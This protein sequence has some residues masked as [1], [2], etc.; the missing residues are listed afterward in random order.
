VSAAAPALDR[1]LVALLAVAC[2]ATVANLYYAQPLLSAIA[3]AFGVSEGTAGL[4]VTVSQV[5]YAT[6]LV[7]VVPLGDLLDRRRLVARLLS[8]C[9]CG[10]ILAGSA[11]ALPVLA[12]ALGAVALT[13]VVVQIL[14]PF[15]STLA[16]ESERGQVVGTIMSGV[17]TGI[18]LARTVSG[19]IAEAAGWRAPFF[20]AAG[21]MAVLGVALWRALPR[22]SP[23]SS[24][25]YGPLVASTGTLIRREPV[26]RRRMAYGALGFAGFTV[27]WTAIAFLLSAPPYSYG[28]RAIGLFGLA[29][30][31]GALGAA[32]FGRLTDRGHGRAATGLVLAAIL[33]S[34]GLLALGKTAVLPLV[35]GL[36]VIDFAVQGQNVLSQG[37]IYALGSEHASRVTTAYV[38]SNF[39]GGALGAAACSLAWTAGGWDAVCATGAA[40]AALAAAFWLTE[41]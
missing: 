6:G 39:V 31:V 11:P 37:Y 10:L 20:V 15:A 26:L 36:V 28:E 23:P 5:A 3:D 27:A 14:I 8:V 19:F 41:S 7:L 22:V 12:L 17:L 18:L 24:L 29:G 40:F 35:A 2:G 30:L 34:W 32:G 25:P 13:S 9:T 21:A 4:L 16:A 33:V 38:T 1:R